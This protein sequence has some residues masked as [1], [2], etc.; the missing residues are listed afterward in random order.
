MLK[1]VAS[2]DAAPS[3]RMP[4]SAAGEVR[5]GPVQ[6][7]PE[8]LREMGVEPRLAFGQAGVEPAVFDHPENRMHLDDLGRLVDVCV[9]LTGHADFGL[10]LGARFDLRGFGPLGELMRHSARVGDA[11]GALLSYLHLQ[12]RSAAPLLL[13]PSQGSVMLGYSIYRHG[14]PA[15]A[16]VLDGSIAIAYRLLAEL[17]GPPWKAQRVQFSHGRPARL[18]EFRRVFGPSLAFDA[19]VS[20]IVFKAEWL[21]KPI[22]GADPLRHLE[23]ARM[24]REAAAEQP[25]SLGD[26][27]QGMLHQMVLNGTA[28]SSAVAQRFGVHERTLRRRLQAQGLSLHRLIG[29]AR[30]ELAQQLLRNTGLS[31]AA[32]AAALGYEDANAFSRAFRGWAQLSPMQWRKQL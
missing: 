21:D 8:L 29:R 3:P 22:D 27:V 2:D 15:S 12:D 25:M 6:T 1:R 17:C 20:A 32:I 11:L 24:L 14:V 19:E 7:L 9:A 26:Q 4:L 28:T 23:L 5:I 16:Q 10:R 13:G 31:V 30:F 18:T